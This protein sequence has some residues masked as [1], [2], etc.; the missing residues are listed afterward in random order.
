MPAMKLGEDLI[1][2]IK[3]TTGG[4]NQELYRKLLG[5]ANEW[6]EGDEILGVAAQSAEQRLVARE[7][8]SNTKISTIDEHPPFQDKLLGWIDQARDMGARQKTNDWTLGELKRF[9]LDEQGDSI[10]RV[11]LGLSSDVIACD[12]GAIEG[13]GVFE[14]L[15]GD[16]FTG[17]IRAAF[18]SSV[19]GPGKQFLGVG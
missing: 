6:K 5:N 7:L 11:A 17:G 2:Y 1:G 13:L 9:L 8:L 15:R 18:S 16:E 12:R 14:L 10:Q 19:C 3:R 4:A